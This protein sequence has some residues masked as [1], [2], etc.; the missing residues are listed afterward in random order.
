MDRD[1]L[2]MFSPIPQLDIPHYTITSVLGH[3]AY[4]SVYMAYHSITKMNVALKVFYKSSLTSNQEA[5]IRREISIMS[6]INM[7]YIVTM[8]EFI[9]TAELICIAMQMANNGNL[10]Q[11]LGRVGK[12]SENE[13]KTFFLQLI[14]ALE[15]LYTKHGIVHRDIKLDNILLG[16]K[17][18][19][20]LSDFGFS[21]RVSEE[22]PLLSTA[23]G[24]PSYMSPEMIKH[25]KHD[26]KT[27]IWSTGVVLY[28]LVTGNAPF[29]GENIG[30]LF[31]QIMRTEPRYPIFLSPDL[32]DLLKHLLDKDPAKRY[33]FEEIYNHR[34]VSN[35]PTFISFIRHNAQGCVL[36]NNAAIQRTAQT[37]QIDEDTLLDLL[38]TNAEAN[39]LAMPIF[40]MSLITE[41]EKL[42]TK[43]NQILD[44]E[45]LKYDCTKDFCK[46]LANVI[47]TINDG[48]N[49]VMNNHKSM[50]LKNG[51][52]NR[53]AI[54][55]S[56]KLLVQPQI[57]PNLELRMNK[58]QTQ[59]NLVSPHAF[60]M[61]RRFSVKSTKP[62]MFRAMPSH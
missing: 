56:N 28:C 26:I 14:S 10:L 41:R 61:V 45:L 5:Q 37:I 3:G 25:D 22:K 16:N 49:E 24:S 6:K 42:F 38:A 17:V 55:S 34:W 23:C 54:A 33:G 8:I 27:D 50:M 7:F 52:R 58:I 1:K 2:D 31:E 51:I 20:L 35:F 11:L 9:E 59:N 15:Y 48:K 30:H 44:A 39:K 46:R 18:N 19:I 57:E 29:V 53:N 36:A 21:D 47:E 40:K 62:R 12:L 13:A 43:I 4:G 60:N 32:V